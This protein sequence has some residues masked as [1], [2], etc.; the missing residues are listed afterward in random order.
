MSIILIIGLGVFLYRIFFGG[1]GS[2]RKI[3]FM[4]SLGHI[5]TS[6]PK[7]FSVTNS[8]SFRGLNSVS[9]YQIKRRPYAEVEELFFDIVDGFS[10]RDILGDEVAGG[11]NSRDS[12][13]S[14]EKLQSKK[15]IDC[16]GGN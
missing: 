1:E 4:H 5:D 2:S 7:L 16:D 8:G 9:R 10:L 6:D 13:G 12:E 11:E 14:V 3:F 15:V